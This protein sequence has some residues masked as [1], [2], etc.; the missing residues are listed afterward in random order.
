MLKTDDRLTIA[1]GSHGDHTTF[2]R[3]CTI[4]HILLAPGLPGS[5]LDI[6]HLVAVLW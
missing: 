3:S 4:E 5:I 1:V 2:I 6:N